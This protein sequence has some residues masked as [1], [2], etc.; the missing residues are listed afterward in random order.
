LLRRA[1]AI[2]EKGFGPDLPT[3]AIR[4]KAPFVPVGNGGR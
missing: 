1:L 4:L 2:D 3:I